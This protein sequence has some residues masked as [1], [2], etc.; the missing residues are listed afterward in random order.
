MQEISI[1]ILNLMLENNSISI[2]DY[3]RFFSTSRLHL[4]FFY[5]TYFQNNLG[6]KIRGQLY[7]NWHAISACIDTLLRGGSHSLKYTPNF[8]STKHKRK[9]LV[10]DPRMNRIEN[11]FCLPDIPGHDFSF[12]QEIFD[13]S[14]RLSK[15]EIIH[16]KG[17]GNVKIDF[18][19]DVRHQKVADF[20]RNVRILFP[21]G[22][23]IEYEDFILVSGK[24]T[25]V[26]SQGPNNI[27][28]PFAVGD[29]FDI[30]YKGEKEF[31]LVVLYETFAMFRGSQSSSYPFSL[32]GNYMTGFPSVDYL[33]TA[34]FCTCDLQYGTITGKYIRNNKVCT[35][36]TIVTPD[37]MEHFKIFR[38]MCT[39]FKV[40]KVHYHQTKELRIIGHQ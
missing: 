14:I 21:Q 28:W 20:F 19:S 6:E 25:M 12:Y 24:S 18:S 22:M 23:G 4:Y 13:E 39:E 37:E 40:K 16:I 35:F 30:V 26:I 33:L 9:L 8:S 29:G 34:P 17:S 10:G 5:L 7:D 31:R 11:T 38:S 32:E 1:L 15:F 2:A 3:S 27:I 36:R